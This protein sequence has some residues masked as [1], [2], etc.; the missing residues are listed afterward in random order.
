MRNASGISW[1]IQMYV[2]VGRELQEWMSK[3]I[4]RNFIPTD[5]YAA[6]FK[7]KKGKK[8]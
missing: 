8:F 5:S 3:K 2:P 1:S 7:K 4:S 6:Y